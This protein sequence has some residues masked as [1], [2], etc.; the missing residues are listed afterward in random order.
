MPAAFGPHGGA[1]INQNRAAA[2]RFRPSALNSCHPGGPV[3]EKSDLAGEYRPR[4]L[5]LPSN[6]R[7]RERLQREGPA[8]LSNA[9]LLAILLRVG[10]AGENTGRVAQRLLAQLNGLPR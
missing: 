5:D 2:L 9:E 8:V 1:I 3:A 4:I 6:H 10:I 7:P